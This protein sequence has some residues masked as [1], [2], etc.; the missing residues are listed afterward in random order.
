MATA[1]KDL[2][3]GRY[4]F[5]SMKEGLKQDPNHKAQ[6]FLFGTTPIVLISD[7]DTVKDF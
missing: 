2:M 4:P 5:I 3:A 1:N 7:V 6:I